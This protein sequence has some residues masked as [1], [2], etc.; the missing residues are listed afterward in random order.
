MSQSRYRRLRTEPYH[1]IHHEHGRAKD[2]YCTMKGTR[3]WHRAEWSIWVQ[4]TVDGHKCWL[5]ACTE[6]LPPMAE[7]ADEN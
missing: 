7:E 3:P 4:S 6:H 1:R 2:G 5:A